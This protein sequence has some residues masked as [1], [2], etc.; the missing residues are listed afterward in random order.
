[1]CWLELVLVLVFLLAVLERGE[2][3]SVGWEFCLFCQGMLAV[4]VYL[5]SWLSQG[6]S[7]GV[8]CASQSYD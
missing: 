7:V 2:I 8:C 5:F 3:V 4:T 1:M 6:G